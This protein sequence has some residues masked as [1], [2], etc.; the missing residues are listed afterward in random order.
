MADETG[1]EAS[2]TQAAFFSRTIDEALALTQETR[3]YL[4]EYSVSDREKLSQAQKTHYAVESMRMTTRLTYAMAWLLAQRAAHQGELS[5]AEL[6]DEQWRLGGQKVCLQ[7]TL[8]EQVFP[9]YFRDLI[10]RSMALY[11][12]I[13]RLDDMVARG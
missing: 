1:A 7:E 12:R 2:S 5:Y 3:D 8:S 11:K 6:R 4:A 9:P 10:R 13:Q